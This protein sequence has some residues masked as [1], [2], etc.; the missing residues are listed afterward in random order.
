MSMAIKRKN[1]SESYKK[2]PRVSSTHDRHTYDALAELADLIDFNH[3]IFEGKP[4]RNRSLGSVQA[5]IVEIALQNEQVLE[6]LRN[7]MVLGGQD[8]Y[9]ILHYRRRY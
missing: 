7:Y 2:L 1:I 3:P 8:W 9:P 6:K 4:M 5:L